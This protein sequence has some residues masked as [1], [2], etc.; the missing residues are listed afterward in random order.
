MARRNKTIFNNLS[1][2]FFGKDVEPEYRSTSTYDMDNGES[3]LFQTKNKDEYERKLTQMKQQKLLSYQW[4]KAGEDRAMESLA[5]LTQVKLMYRDADLMDSMPEIGSALDIVAE[6][7]CTLNSK[8]KMINVYSKS[9][10]IKSILEDLFT[11]RLNDSVILP[12]I[13]RSMCKY[14]NEFMLLNIN[15]K[16]GVMGWKELP[17]YEIERIENGF[18]NST[19]PA[20]TTSTNK[21]K[22]EET[23]FKWMGKNEGTEYK[24]WQIAHFRLLTDSFFLPYGVSYLHKARR[25]WRMLSMMEDAMLIYRL[26]KSIE[27]RVY[28]IYVGTIDDADVPAFVQEVAN[29]FKRTPVIDPLTGQVD[30]RKNF[31]DVSTD[32]FIPVRNESTPNPIETLPGATN[33]TSMDDI[34]YMQNKILSALRIPKTFLNFEEPQGKGQNLSL[35]DI[36]FCRMINRIQQCILLELN[37]IALIHLYILGFRDDLTNFSLSLNNPSAQIEALELEDLTKRI[38][39]ATAALADPGTGIPLMSIHRVLK[40]IMKMTDNEIKDMLN[41]IRLEKAMAAELATTQTIIKKTGIFDNVDRIYGDYDAMNQPQQAQAQQDQGLGS[42]G[43]GAMGGGMDMGGSLSSDSLGGP[44]EELGSDIGGESEE[45]GMPEAPAAD[46][47]KPMESR[48]IKKPILV[49]SKASPKNYTSFMEKY[50]NKIG[51]KEKEKK[52]EINKA[53]KFTED[54]KFINEEINEAFDAIDKILKENKEKN[55]EDDE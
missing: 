47:G 41:E 55:T 51:Y 2:V 28:K 32:Y 44:G 37:K 46:E 6:E 34:K 54:N 30:L 12:M 8:G 21:I 48:K 36:R 19:T 7:A 22:V 10:R 39:T 1:D 18:G 20:E 24:N 50:L 5:G 38:Q 14:G 35:L 3:I 40:E 25:A 45:V 13:V 52:E 23:I 49:E 9:N 27:R 15:E 17:I 4:V 29:N 43:G 16:N 11:N 53:L 33:L 26:D 31:M 42:G